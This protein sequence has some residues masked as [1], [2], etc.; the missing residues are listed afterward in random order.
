M[1]ILCNALLAIGAGAREI[2]AGSWFL[3]LVVQILLWSCSDCI[4]DIFSNIGTSSNTLLRAS[5]KMCS[6]LIVE[7]VLALLQ[8]TQITF[9]SNPSR[10]YGTFNSVKVILDLIC[11]LAVHCSSSMRSATI[12]EA[13]FF[14]RGLCNRIMHVQALST[15]PPPC[16]EDRTNCDPGSR[17]VW[18]SKSASPDHYDYRRRQGLNIRSKHSKIPV[19]KSLQGSVPVL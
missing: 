5:Q 10:A 2:K 12:F 11:H 15:T 4:L 6:Q 3:P 14:L 7:P 8:T 17:L 18:G 13:N 1:G 9:L 16:R 19:Q